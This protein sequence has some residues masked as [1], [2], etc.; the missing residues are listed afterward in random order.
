M[1][2]NGSRLL[3]VPNVPS[4]QT[5]GAKEEGIAAHFI[6]QKIIESGSNDP[7]E[8]VGMKTPN[9][10]F[11]TREMLQVVLQYTDEILLR[12]ENDIEVDV[13][14]TS[15]NRAYQINA[16]ADNAVLINDCLFV[17]DFKYGFRKVEATDNWTLIAYA[18]GFVLLHNVQPSQIRFT[19]H[20]PRID[21]FS[22]WVISWAELQALH[23][24]LHETL[25]NLDDFLTTGKQCVKCPSVALCPAAK[26]AGFN[27][28]EYTE[29]A[30]TDTL[31][32]DQLSKE[33]VTLKSAERAIKSRIEAL[34]EIA[35]FKLKSGEIIEGF[36]LSQKLGNTTWLPE[37]SPEML[38]ALYGEKI[39]SYKPVTPAQARRNEVPENFIEGATF[40][41]VR[42]ISLV[43]Q[44]ANDT[45][46]RIFNN[47]KES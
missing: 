34:E 17:D 26:E 27:A 1:E 9:G 32:N 13:S 4:G 30:F 19:I 10:I 35:K 6:A 16:R 25:C 38:K 41:P 47:K 44:D 18:L 42:G 45:A 36:A 12:S 31:S 2:C 24:K 39:V 33:L 23:V 29:T 3:G 7:S 22:E 14:L 20:Q 11:V 5:N 46:N 43:Q 37:F 40:R 28:V 8:F 15:E 21:N